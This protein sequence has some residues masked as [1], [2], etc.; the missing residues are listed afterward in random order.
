MFL[1]TGVDDDVPEHRRSSHRWLR[2]GVWPRAGTEPPRAKKPPTGFLDARPETQERTRGP[3]TEKSAPSQ[4]EARPPP[5]DEPGGQVRPPHRVGASGPH[6]RAKPSKG[7]GQSRARRSL[8]FSTGADA[9][10]LPGSVST[11]TPPFP[12]PRMHSAGRDQWV[13]QPTASCGVGHFQNSA[14]REHKTVTPSPVSYAG[15]AEF[16]QRFMPA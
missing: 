14:R 11:A 15:R 10:V 12:A 4:R 2:T 1:D 7:A 3:A 5:D 9:V 13:P 6:A 16:L 8:V